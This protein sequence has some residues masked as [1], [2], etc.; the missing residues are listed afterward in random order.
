MKLLFKG[1]MFS[2]PETIED[3]IAM[4][5]LW[6]HEILRVYYDRLVDDSDCS[7]FFENLYLVCKEFLNENMNDM[8]VHLTNGKSGTVNLF[9]I[10]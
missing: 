2:V 9:N 3:A 10:I 4:K 5:R 8:F 1:V 6:V 7:W